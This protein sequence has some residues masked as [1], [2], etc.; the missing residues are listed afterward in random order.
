MNLHDLV[1]A[2]CIYAPAG[3]IYAQNLVLRGLF[4]EVPFRK[5]TL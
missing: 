5:N 3:C 4:W 2:A 1:A